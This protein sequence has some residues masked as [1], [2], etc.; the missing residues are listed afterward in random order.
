[1]ILEFYTLEKQNDLSINE[2]IYT[3]QNGKKRTIQLTQIMGHMTGFPKVATAKNNKN[4]RMEVSEQV[5]MIITNS[6][7]CKKEAILLIFCH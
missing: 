5:H 2:R 3:K 7:L 6:L 1:M 4:K